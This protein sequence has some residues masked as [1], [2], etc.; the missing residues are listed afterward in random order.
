MDA[1]VCGGCGRV[2]LEAAARCAHC[3][4]ETEARE[5]SGRGTLYAFSAVH[6]GPP[7]TPTPYLLALVELEEGGRVLARLEDAGGGEPAIGDPVAFS[8]LS[9]AGPVFRKVS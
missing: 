1:S 8:G 7:G 3:G 2:R 5:A 9:E 4:G 6:M